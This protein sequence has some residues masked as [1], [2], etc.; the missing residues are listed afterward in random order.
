MTA[1]L[2]LV[3]LPAAV[4][5]ESGRMSTANPLFQKLMPGVVQDRRERLA[6]SD[7][8]ADAMLADALNRL[9][10]RT[11]GVQSIPLA[12]RVHQNPMV[13]HLLPVRGSAH[14]IFSQASTIVVVTP[15]DRA[16]VPTA[17]IL[18]GLFDLTPA[19][20]RI[21]RAIGAGQS[22]GDIAVLSGV[23]VGTVRGQLKAVLAKT[24]V[25]RQAE[26]ALL[27]SGLAL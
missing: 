21:A 17:E 8:A 15:V 16:N 12:A 6:L 5:R 23:S 24:G 4:L 9:A 3:G 20:A 7:L 14:D 22:V 27:L 2:E 18:E 26:L 25:G 1:A 13:M 10:A 19:E 11:E